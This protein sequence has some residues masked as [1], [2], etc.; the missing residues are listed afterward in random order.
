MRNDKLIF[1]RLYKIDTSKGQDYEGQCLCGSL[2]HP[3]YL[4]GLELLLI[5]SILRFSNFESIFYLMNVT[6]RKELLI[7]YKVLVRDYII[8]V[9]FRGPVMILLFQKMFFSMFF[10][11]KKS[12]GF[13][14]NFYILYKLCLLVP[15]L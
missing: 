7:C 2:R 15:N 12:R 14:L 8:L 4:R 13:N 11:L 9:V 10:L 5:N 1:Y 6:I 3:F